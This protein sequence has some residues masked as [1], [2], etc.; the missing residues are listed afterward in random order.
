MMKKLLL[1]AALAAPVL[2]FDAAFA[3]GEKP[4]HGG[5][6]QVVSDLTFE[7]VPKGDIATIHVEDHGK[8]MPTTGMT[9]KLTVLNGTEKSEVELKPAGENRLEAQGVKLTKGAK[10]IAS[11]TTPKKKTISVRFAVK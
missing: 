9:G 7:L 1:V 8:P 4:K 2:V 3:H 11:I 5:V 10:A 6:V